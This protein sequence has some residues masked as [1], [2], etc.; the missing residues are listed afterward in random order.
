[1]INVPVQ[2]QCWTGEDGHAQN[3][4]I[5]VPVHWQCWTGGNGHTQN[6][7]IN[8]PVHWQYWTGGDGHTDNTMI[9]V[10]VH[11]QCWTALGIDPWTGW[12]PCGLPL[13][14]RSLG[15]R[16]GQERKET[17]DR[18]TFQSMCADWH[19]NRQH[20]E[21]QDRKWRKEWHN[22]CYLQ[23]QWYHT[24]YHVY[25]LTIKPP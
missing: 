20:V 7:M 16:E 18:V 1:M 24:N 6:T 10:P 5:N 2:W 23:T 22:A 4:M 12:H 17:T 19:S 15:F 9:N 14:K 11:Q 21:K 25:R 13:V 3:T 8:V